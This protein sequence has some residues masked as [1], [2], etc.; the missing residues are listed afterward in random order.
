[1]ISETHSGCLARGATPI[2]DGF[3]SWLVS[4]LAISGEEQVLELGCGNGTFAVRLAKRVRQLDALDPLAQRAATRFHVPIN[5]R[6]I[7]ERVEDFSFPRRQ[8]DLILSMEAFHL[9]S[10]PSA[11]L[12]DCFGAVKPGGP[13]VICWVEFFWEDALLSDIVQSFRCVGVDWGEAGNLAAIDASR[14]APRISVSQE[15]FNVLQRFKVEDVAA[16]LLTVSK[17]RGLSVAAASKLLGQLRQRF[18][19]SVNASGDLVGESNYVAQIMREE[20]RE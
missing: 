3:V 12:R 13:V 18:A 19:S 16:Y 17:A 7:A 15:R 9:F 20:C 10:D 4:R 5:M 1:M 8:Y 11:V 2:P 14:W 6:L